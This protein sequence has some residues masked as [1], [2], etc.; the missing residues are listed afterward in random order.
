MG[1]IKVNIKKLIQFHPPN[2]IQ[3]TIN[4]QLNY[5]YLNK[6]LNSTPEHITYVTSYTQ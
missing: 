2:T 1:V 3:G 6:T 5:T 4:K